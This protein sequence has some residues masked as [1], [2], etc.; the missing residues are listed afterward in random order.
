MVSYAVVCKMALVVFRV[1]VWVASMETIKY[2]H[3]IRIL[4]FILKL[5]TWP[6][7][8]LPHSSCLKEYLYIQVLTVWWLSRKWKSPYK[9]Q[10]NGEE[11][12]YGK[13]SCIRSLA[14]RQAKQLF[15]KHSECIANACKNEW[16]WTLGFLT[17]MCKFTECWCYCSRYGTEII[18]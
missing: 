16:W 18:W 17:K 2:R 1:F 11:T 12:I 13:T 7:N 14:H 6:A 3:L 10:W 4:I 8:E 5:V 15:L 9:P